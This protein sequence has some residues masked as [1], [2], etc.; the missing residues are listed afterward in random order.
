M[1]ATP[2][3]QPVTGPLQCGQ[4]HKDRVLFQNVQTFAWDLQLGLLDNAKNFD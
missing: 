2:P 4:H 3:A 1:S